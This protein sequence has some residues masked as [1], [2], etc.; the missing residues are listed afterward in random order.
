M[1]ELKCFTE[2]FLAVFEL[3]EVDEDA[4]RREVYPVGGWA[5]L[6]TYLKVRE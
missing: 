1:L 6:P 2:E 4:A 3:I 5:E